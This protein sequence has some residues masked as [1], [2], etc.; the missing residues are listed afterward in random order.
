MNILK[1]L[2]KTVKS[3]RSQLFTLLDISW[4]QTITLVSNVSM[5]SVSK[6]LGIK[7]SPQHCAKTLDKE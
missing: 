5:E 4:Q 6:S 1:S 2:L 3:R 7:A